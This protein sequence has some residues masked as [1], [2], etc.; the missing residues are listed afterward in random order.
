ME[1]CEN[2]NL[3][4][5]LSRNSAGF[6]NEVEVSRESLNSDGYLTPT[7]NAQHETQIYLVS[8]FLLKAFGGNIYGRNLHH[9]KALADKL[10]IM[11]AIMNR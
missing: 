1:Y 5:Y 11:I 9:H 8:L 3:K 4:D 2:N 7:R 6:L 10:R